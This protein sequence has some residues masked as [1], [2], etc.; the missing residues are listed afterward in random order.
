MRDQHLAG[1]ELAQDPDVGDA[2]SD[3]GHMP[4]PAFVDQ[5]VEHVFRQIVVDLDEGVAVRLCEADQGARIV[6]CLQHQIAVALR[7]VDAPRHDHVRAG[8]AAVLDRRPYLSDEFRRRGPHVEHRRHAVREVDRHVLLRRRMRMHVGQAGRQVGGAAAVDDAR[9]GRHRERLPDGR[10]GAVLHEHGPVAQDLRV[11]HRHDV[12]VDERGAGRQRCAALG[13]CGCRGVDGDR[14]GG[15]TAAET[16]AHWPSR[17]TA[18]PVRGFV[19]VTFSSALMRQ[20]P[21]R[22]VSTARISVSTACG[23]A[24]CAAPTVRRLQKWTIAPS[25]PSASTAIN[26]FANVESL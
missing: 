11:V 5:R 13:M 23:P 3:H 1:G 14:D 15:E 16:P 20:P 6:G 4:A 17:R 22:R 21:S 24:G 18:S 19:S 7:A 10:D 12:D 8:D 2:M 25:S 9:A 26:S